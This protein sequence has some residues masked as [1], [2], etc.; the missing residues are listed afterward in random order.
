[1]DFPLP[2]PDEREATGR[3]E[4]SPMNPPRRRRAAAAG[5]ISANEIAL[6]FKGRALRPKVES[7]LA[8]LLRMGIITQAAR[9][10]YHLTRAA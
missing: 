7:V 2:P 8:G 5:A 4:A 6:R 9:G 3:H 10:T 1:M